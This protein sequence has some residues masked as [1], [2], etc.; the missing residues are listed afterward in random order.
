MRSALERHDTMVRSAI[1]AHG[2]YVFAT[3]DD[4]FC[5]AFGRADEALSA[6]V[7]L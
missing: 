2:G 3:G 1:E 4:G 6:A 7:E 5:V